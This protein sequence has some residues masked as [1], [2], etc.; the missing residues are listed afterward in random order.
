VFTAEITALLSAL[1]FVG[2]G[3]PGEFLIL[4]DSLSSIEAKKSCLLMDWQRR[5]DGGDMGMYAISIFLRVRLSPWFLDVVV[6][7]RVITV[8]SHLISNHYPR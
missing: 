3:Q 7:R 5:W 6:A 8:I 4:T 2:S 1:R